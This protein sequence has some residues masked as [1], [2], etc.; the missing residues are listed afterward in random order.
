MRQFVANCP[1]I[2]ISI[3]K[4]PHRKRRSTIW[5]I[6]RY[7]YSHISMSLVC[8]ILLHYTVLKYTANLPHMAE[9]TAM[10]LKLKDVPQYLL[11]TAP[12]DDDPALQVSDDWAMV[13]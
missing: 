1:I 6:I 7:E 3:G 4:Y 11:A 9:L 12:A 13:T 10:A 2:S 8:T 5:N